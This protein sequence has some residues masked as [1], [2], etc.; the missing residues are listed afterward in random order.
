[1]SKAFTKESE[2]VPEPAIRRRGVAVPIDVPNYV[3]AAGVRALRAEL[4]SCVDE[5]RRREISDHLA[6]AIAMDLPAVRNRV[7]FGATVTVED[8]DGKRT[9]YRLVG[10]I[11]A[12]PRDGAIYFRSPIAEALDDAQVG[13]T[14]ALPRDEV[15]V[16]AIEY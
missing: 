9:R 2:N 8:G 13:D 12:S 4:A 6:T 10:A 7:G 11:E 5:D 15:E 14:V 1:M 3:T 16:V